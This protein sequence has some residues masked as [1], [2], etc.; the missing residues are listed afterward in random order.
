MIELTSHQGNVGDVL[1]IG[2]QLITDALVSE[3]EENEIRDQLINLNDRWEALRVSAMDR[4]SRSVAQRS[5]LLVYTK[6][7]N[8]HF[9]AV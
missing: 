5:V 4:Q 3:K 1:G 7:V 8:I 9:R 2:N 6:P